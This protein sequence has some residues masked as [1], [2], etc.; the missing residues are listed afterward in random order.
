MYSMMM[1]TDLHSPGPQTNT[2]SGQTGPNSGNKANQDRVKRPMNA[3]MVW[4]R[5]Q[6]RKMAQENPKMH[7]SEISKRLGAEWKVM[8][9]AEKRPFIDEAKRLRA[10]H[11]KEHPDYKYRPRRKTKTLL[12]KDKYSLAGGL[13]AGAGSG[14]GVG[15]L[16]VG[17]SPAG[18]GQR[19]ESPGGHG[20]TASAGYA[21]MN[22][23]ANGTYSGQVAAAAA[24]AA[25]MQEAQL[26]YSQHPGG[27]AHH[28]HPHHHHPHNPQPMHRYDMTALQYSPISNSQSYMSASPSGYGGISYAQHQNSSVASSGTIGTLGSLVKSEPSV[29]PPVTTHSRAPCPG[30]LRE[31]ISMYLPTGEAGDPSV[32]SRLHTLPQHYQSPAA[33][34]NGT[35]PLTHI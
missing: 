8:S 22:G 21:H 35:V 3:F 12:K 29:S 1:E 6:R 19:L 15:G 4:S 24:A 16:G 9:E 13:L 20:G 34:V 5:G 33:G 32:Q 10:M 27:G 26:A 28:H 11:M 30:D 18:V 23:W 2:N 25:M 14:G 7:N 31:M 17:M